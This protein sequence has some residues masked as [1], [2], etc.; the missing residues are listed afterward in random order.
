MPHGTAKDSMHLRNQK[1]LN[2]VTWIML[3]VFVSTTNRFTLQS[4]NS[5]CVGLV[6]TVCFKNAVVW[7]ASWGTVGSFSLQFLPTPA[8]RVGCCLMCL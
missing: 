5:V 3:A 6:C 2:K 1:A 7:W 4:Y 8:V